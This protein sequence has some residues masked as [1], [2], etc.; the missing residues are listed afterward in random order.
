MAC[1]LSKS[2]GEIDGE[3]QK[4]YYGRTI[5]HNELKKEIYEITEN[6]SFT[7]LWKGKL[8]ESLVKYGSSQESVHDFRLWQFA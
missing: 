5:E 8:L 7:K 3:Q 6:E 1:K 4:E 2:A